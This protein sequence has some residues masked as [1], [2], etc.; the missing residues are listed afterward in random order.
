MKP[1]G[2]ISN[3]FCEVKEDNLKRLHIVCFPSYDILE[4]WGYKVGLTTEEQGEI[5]GVMG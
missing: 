5:W 3:E 1:H 4:G 2:W